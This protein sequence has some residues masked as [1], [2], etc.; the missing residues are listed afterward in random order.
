VKVIAEG[1][2]ISIFILFFTLCV[3]I[4][5][6]R[7]RDWALPASTG[8]FFIGLYFVYVLQQVARSKFGTCGEV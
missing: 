6:I 7:A 1:F 4:Y 8:W 5:T 3:M 2:E